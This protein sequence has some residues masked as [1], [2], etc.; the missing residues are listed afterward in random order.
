MRERE[1]LKIMVRKDVLIIE[2]QQIQILISKYQIILETEQGILLFHKLFQKIN[3]TIDLLGCTHE[4][5]NKWIKF[6]FTEDK[7]LDKY[8]SIWNFDHTLTL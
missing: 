4:F 6:K 2:I 8:G 5:I 1:W 3:K 7:T